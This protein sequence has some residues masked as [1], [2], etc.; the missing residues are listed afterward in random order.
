MRE[1]EFKQINN[2]TEHNKQTSETKKQ[3][4]MEQNAEN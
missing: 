1:A 4:N 3:R 2:Q